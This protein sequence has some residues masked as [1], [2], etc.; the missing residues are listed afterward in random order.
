MPPRAEL[1]LV[2]LAVLAAAG[3]GVLA[4]AASTAPGPA[5]A[6]A[7]PPH[8]VV[9]TLDTVRADRLGAYGHAA[10][11]TPRL[12]RLAREGALVER[13]QAV[14]PLT[15]PAHASLFTG[16]YPPA[17]GVRDNADFVL[18]ASVTTLA[19]VLAARGYRTAAVVG[20]A[21][22]ARTQGLAQGFASY[23]EPGA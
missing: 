2:W 22:L 15:L 17:H 5:A 14:A 6:P 19:E 18:P 8:L 13:T 3:S 4:A 10:A 12:D 9:V 21:V 11:A 16:L 1:V 23:D 7:V 20:A